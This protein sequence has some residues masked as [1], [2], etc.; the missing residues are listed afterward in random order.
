MYHGYSVETE[1]V[2]FHKSALKEIAIFF[3]VF[4]DFLLKKNSSLHHLKERTF[5]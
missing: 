5:F 4:I 2:N 3:K 1:K